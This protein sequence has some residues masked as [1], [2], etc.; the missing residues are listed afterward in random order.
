MNRKS[1]FVRLMPYLVR[2]QGW[3]LATLPLLIVVGIVA[4]LAK[5]WPLKVVLDGILFQKYPEFLP[6]SWRGE[7]NVERILIGCCLAV[8]VIALVD[9]LAA[10]AR[11]LI[12]AAAGLKAVRRIRR[13]LVQRIQALSLA[14][15]RRRG[16]GDL[17]IRVTGDVSLL[18]EFLLDALLD[19]AR[20]GLVVV[21]MLAMM[22]WLDWRLTLAALL[23]IPPFL[24]LLRLFTPGIKAA[25]RSQR[26]KE[27][28]LATDVS[29]AIA[30]LPV[31]Q[32]FC[33]ENRV[34][35]RVEE[36]NR[37]SARAGMRTTRLE[38]S[39]GR[40][41]ELLLALGT[42]VVLFL[43]AK[44]A[45]AGSLTP[46][47]LVVLV[48]YLRAVYKPIRNMAGRSSRLAK[49]SACAERVIE[50]LDM[51]PAIRDSSA[52]QPA[53]VLSGRIELRDVSFTYGG[54]DVLEHA[55]LAIEPGEV[56]ALVGRSGAGKTT[57]AHLLSRFHDPTSGS[58][59]IDGHDVR[60]FTLDSLR[61][62]VGFVMQETVLM[63][64]TIAENIALARPAA[65]RAEI[66][67]AARSAGA[68]EFI[69]RFPDG[70]D[71]EVAERGS[72]LSG[73]QAR[74]IALA[75]VLLKNPPIVVLDEP[76]TGLDRA[77]EEAVSHGLLEAVRGKTTLLIAHRFALLP[78]VDRIAV[79]DSGRI[80]EFGS[81]D[82]LLR[83]GGFYARLFCERDFDDRVLL[84]EG[85]EAVT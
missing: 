29:E 37:S 35:D 44:R 4:E 47:D 73:G 69:L 27:G 41:S 30:A 9:A 8:F 42:A 51:E 13:D 71:T 21:G 50:I 5:P 31:V 48:T 67:Q 40:I 75:R 39:F 17:L 12:S 80:V 19:L 23:V 10:Y 84:N 15:H 7:Q 14:E 61:Q 79:L 46:G 16:G 72:T 74:R 33:I 38:A 3:T 28:L 77:S 32:S 43:G 63:K 68:E 34:C 2:R 59:R 83:R 20:N 52:A 6:D 57:L 58:V 82:Q 56:I 36:Q 24:I 64:G 62:Q 70:Y 25:V 1:T 49:A 26:K 53:P 65:S 76:L 66:E 18:R 22:L 78:R 85:M 45:L 54:G 60:D 81:H 55:D 11:T